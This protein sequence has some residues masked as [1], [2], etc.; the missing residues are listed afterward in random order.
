MWL[1]LFLAKITIHRH[2]CPR[3]HGFGINKLLPRAI[4]MIPRLVPSQLWVHRRVSVNQREREGKGK[5]AT[6]ATIM[7]DMSYRPRLVE[8]G[9]P[10][11]S[12]NHTFKEDED[13]VNMSIDMEQHD[14]PTIRSSLASALGET[15]A[16]SRP[17]QTRPKFRITIG[18]D[19]G[20]LNHSS[21][22]SMSQNHEDGIAHSR[23]TSHRVEIGCNHQLEEVVRMEGV[24]VHTL[25]QPM[26]VLDG[27]NIAFAY[28]KAEQQGTMNAQPNVRGILVAVQYWKRCSL[29][30]LVVLPQPWMDPRKGHVG[31]LEGIAGML[32]TAPSRDDDDAY[33]LQLAW[34]ENVRAV[35]PN[36]RIE[37]PAYV[38]S[39]DMFRDAQA[40]DER[41]RQWL[42]VGIQESLGIGRISYTF[43]D[44][45]QFDDH[46]DPMLDFI[47]NPRHP[48]VL[49]AEQ[50]HE[51][52]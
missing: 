20:N 17:R 7:F 44:A 24:Q 6:Q 41:L 16:L 34:R 48:L 33:A 35:R 22:P 37:G 40:R 52:R 50:Q 36:G 8:E 27:A 38:L 2:L 29:R 43:A 46:G 30:V 39:N 12:T 42:Q 4:R 32:V 31:I 18:E 19:Q 3:R 47:P 1:N 15:S 11:G 21:I 26:V 23:P 5:I 51:Q 25:R 10:I 45:G 28:G 13:D 49:W 14:H 9:V